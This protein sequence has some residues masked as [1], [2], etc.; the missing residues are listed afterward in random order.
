MATEEDLRAASAPAISIEDGRARA[1]GVRLTATV[2]VV[3]R[4]EHVSLSDLDQASKQARAL[5]WR[6]SDLVICL[7]AALPDWI[8]RTKSST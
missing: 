6:L 8:A 2:L 1:L 5:D 4:G 3:P 7:V